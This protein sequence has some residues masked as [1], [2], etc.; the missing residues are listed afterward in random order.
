MLAE[1]KN[2]KYFYIQS[3]I[4]KE[5]ILNYTLYVRSLSIVYRR[6]L[7]GLQDRVTPAIIVEPRTRFVL[8]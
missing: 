8:F 2:T 4:H 7:Y 1:L 6:K 3:E 5:C